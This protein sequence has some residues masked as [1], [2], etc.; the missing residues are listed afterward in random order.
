MRMPLYLIGFGV[1]TALFAVLAAIHVTMRGQVHR[2]MYGEQE[3]KPTDVRYANDL[4]GESGVW[5]LHRRAYEQSRLRG[6][7]WCVLVACLVCLTLGLFD[8]LLVRG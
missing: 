4:L 6:L 8:L 2:A 1:G 3:I 5:N 7:F